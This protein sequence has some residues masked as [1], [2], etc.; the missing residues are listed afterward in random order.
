[1]NTS[2]MVG[3]LED[4][5]LEPTTP[6]PIKQFELRN[7][8]SVTNKPKQYRNNSMPTIVPTFSVMTIRRY[9]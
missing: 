7:E 4:L 5:K 9:E 3:K 8:M 6:S 1:M 2:I